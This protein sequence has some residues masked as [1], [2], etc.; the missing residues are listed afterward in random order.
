MDEPHKNATST[1]NAWGETKKAITFKRIH[2]Y[3][4]LNGEFVADEFFEFEENYDEEDTID[5]VYKNKISSTAKHGKY[6]LKFEF[7]DG[8]SV[9]N[10]CF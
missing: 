3:H 5:F 6:R 8:E 2:V 9:V 7:I 4:F 1:I 10:G